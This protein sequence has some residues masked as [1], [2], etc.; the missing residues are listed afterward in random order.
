MN[1]SSSRLHLA[2]PRDISALFRDSFAV[3][4]AHFRTFFLIGAAIVVP[5]ELIVAGIG[6]E[7]LTASYDSTTSL[8]ETIVPTLVSFL[9]VAPL[10]TVI[11]IHALQQLAAGG[12]PNAREA[13]IA[14]FEIFTPLFF[15]VALATL[16]TA[17]GLLVIVPGLYLFV[18]WYFVPQQVVF[19]G[20][21][22]VRALTRSGE[23]TTGFWWRT[24]GL[25][26]IVNIAMLIPSLVL[27]APFAALAENSDRA[28]WSLVGSTLTETVTAP[29]VAIFSTLLWFDLRARRS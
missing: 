4:W 26:L 19:E 6:Q 9:V 14:G 7:Q 22:G 10:I 27:T 13:L 3:Y 12:Q 29:F 16:G 18:R 15:A 21:R 20:D 2:H 1:T 23:Q 5:V 8:Q 25:I 11:C 28:L 17:V 24:F